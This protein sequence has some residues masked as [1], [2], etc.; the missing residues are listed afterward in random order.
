MP[1][2]LP[3]PGVW[4]GSSALSTAIPT[5][6]RAPDAALHALVDTRQ[7][8]GIWD[9]EVGQGVGM[10]SPQRDTLGMERPKS[11]PAFWLGQ[12]ESPMQAALSEVLPPAAN[13]GK[14]TG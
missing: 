4:G 12:M 10:R 8:G 14:K 5:F 13:R 3:S 9:E 2:G 6:I 11:E 7:G 1:S